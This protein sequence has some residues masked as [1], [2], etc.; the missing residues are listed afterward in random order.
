MKKSGITI[1]F[2]LLPVLCFFVQKRRRVYFALFYFM[3]NI[4]PQAEEYL[5]IT[6]VEIRALAFHDFRGIDT[7]AHQIHEHLFLVV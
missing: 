2:V 6:Q 5:V 3:K 1:L 4:C 7:S